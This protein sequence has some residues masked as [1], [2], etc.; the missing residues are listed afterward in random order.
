M[1][2]HF[3]KEEKK[4]LLYTAIITISVLLILV[5]IRFIHSP[6]TVEDFAGGGGG[7]VEINFGDSDWGAGEDFTS[8]VLNVTESSNNF[9]AAIRNAQE[10]EILAQ[11]NTTEKSDIVVAKKP[12][13]ETKVKTKTQPVTN[14]VTQKSK[15][16]DNTNNALSSILSGNTKG[17]DGV[18]GKAGNQGKPDGSLSSDN[19]YGDGGSGGG[20]GGGHGI[21]KGTGIGD[22][23]GT[24]T[25]GGVG[26][27]LAGRKAV[28][29]PA[30]KNNCNQA[31]KVVV[32]VLVDR[33]GNVV[34]AEPG[35]KGTTNNSGCLLNI[36]KTAALNTKWESKSSA[37][38]EQEGTIVYNFTWKGN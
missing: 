16:S 27:S 26:Y 6:Q 4:S 5:Y 15:V 37:P 21:G 7:G 34:K 8:E 33:N 32:R 36:A 12:Q 10:D 3:S 11:E 23:E 29:K 20:S 1:L 13:T 9:S 31:G 35:V 28:S 19:Y 17:G 14:P 30:P 24:G 18:T 25:G 2:L 22:G 38:S